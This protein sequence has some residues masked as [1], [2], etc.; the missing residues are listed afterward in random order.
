MALLLAG[1]DMGHPARAAATPQNPMPTPAPTP[2]Y[3][4]VNDILN[5]RRQLLRC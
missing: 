1:A 5:G 3:S 4:N 2:D